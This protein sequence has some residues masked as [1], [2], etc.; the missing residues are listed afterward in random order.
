MIEAWGKSLGGTGDDFGNG[1][2]TDSNGNVFVTGWF[3]GTTMT[4][5]SNT[6]TSNGSDDI[7]VL[8]FAPSAPSAPT[9]VSATSVT[10]TS[11]IVSFTSV[12]GATN[13]TVT[14]SIGSITATGTSSPITITGLSPNT[15]Y[16]F[17]VTATKDEFFL[18]NFEKYIQHLLQLY[19]LLQNV[20]TEYLAPSVY[21]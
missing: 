4:F 19:F 3:K 21:I 6:L 8:K 2:A 9:G 7:F 17:T 11:A 12:T 16:T 5:A 1:I 10:S 15:S 18:L 20:I 13:Y 14:S